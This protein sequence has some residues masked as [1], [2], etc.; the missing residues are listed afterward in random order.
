MLHQA[1]RRLLTVGNHAQIIF[2]LT[3]HKSNGTE[4]KFVPGTL[5]E[6]TN[7]SI[8]PAT[9]KIVYQAQLSD[10][11]LKRIG[12]PF[13]VDPDSVQHCP[14]RS[15]VFNIRKFWQLKS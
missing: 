5:V 9:K 1:T 7:I 6:I 15:L 3:I 10:T 12:D 2:P 14:N 8:N 11:S 4:E 13:Y